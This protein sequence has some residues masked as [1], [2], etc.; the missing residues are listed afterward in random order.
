[1]PEIFNAGSCARTA[2]GKSAGVKTAPVAG[3]VGTDSATTAGATAAAGGTGRRTASTGPRS[4]AVS[5]MRVASTARAREDIDGGGGT[6]ELSNAWAALS[7]GEGAVRFA[8]NAG[9]PGCAGAVAATAAAAGKSVGAGPG[10]GGK[11]DRGVP[12][13]ADGAATAPSPPWGALRCTIHQVPAAASKA[14]QATPAAIHSTTAT[15][16]PAV[17]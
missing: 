7:R 11:G 13:S 12:D 16:R 4:G 5:G 3:S 6:A 17:E 8:G 15:G 14:T 9:T 2:S 1:M 10:A